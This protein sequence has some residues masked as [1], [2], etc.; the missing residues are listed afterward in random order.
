[1]ERLTT[2]ISEG[3]RMRHSLSLLAAPPTRLPKAAKE[4]EQLVENN[5]YIF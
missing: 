5:I 1:M 2:I 3:S 4:K